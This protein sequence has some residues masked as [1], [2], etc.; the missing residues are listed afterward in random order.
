MEDV[1]RNDGILVE[2]G[3]ESGDIVSFATIPNDSDGGSLDAVVQSVFRFPYNL[4]L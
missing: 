1:R 3:V 2:V 4:L